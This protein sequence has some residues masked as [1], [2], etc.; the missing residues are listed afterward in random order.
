ML[1][2]VGNNLVNLD[3]VISIV[4]DDHFITLRISGEK[5]GIYE[6]FATEEEAKIEFEKLTRYV[7]RSGIAVYFMGK[8]K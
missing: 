3:N 1:I 6:T 4:Q 2:K 5:N 7:T 8:K